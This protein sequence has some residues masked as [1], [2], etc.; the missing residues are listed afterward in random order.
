MR[1]LIALLLVLVP[2]AGCSEDKAPSA[3]DVDDVFGDTKAFGVDDE[4]G[5]ILGVVVDQGVVPVPGAQ[6]QV[7]GGEAAVD[8]DELGRF[9]IPHVP[10]GTHFLNVSKLNYGSTQVSITVVAGEERPLA[11][12]VQ[13][14]RLYGGAPFTVPDYFQ[15]F[16]TCGYDVNA[17]SSLCLNDYT[18]FIPIVGDDGGIAQQLQET[19]LDDREHWYAI[20]ADWQTHVV[21][22]TWEP[23]S[24]STSIRM[25]GIISHHPR[26][27][28][29][30]YA[31]DAGENPVLIRMEQG[32]EHFDRQDQPS[33]VP[34]EGLENMEFFAAVDTDGEAGPPYST[35]AVT[36]EQEFEVFFHTF[37]YGKPPADWS[38]MAGHPKP[39]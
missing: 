15:G 23:S 33:L 18:R 6:V 22:L 2:L 32:E 21:E 10:A 17:A 36:V 1:I 4:H 12:K 13:I 7:L 26:P 8:S 5:V 9:V 37:Y 29:H 30:W 19:G 11:L 39:F 25:R 27:A 20:D 31:S 3:A 34:P 14:E 24:D 38:F 35:V 28:T 16:I